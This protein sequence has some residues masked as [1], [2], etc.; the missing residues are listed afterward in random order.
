[1]TVLWQAAELLRHQHLQPYVLNVHLKLNSPRRTS[2]PSQWSETEKGNTRTIRFSEP[3]H[4][5]PPA[6]IERRSSCGNDRTLNPSVSGAEQSY[7]S[8]TRI[9]GTNPSNLHPK[10]KE[11][12]SG[13]THEGTVITKTI[14]SKISRNPQDTETKASSASKRK[15]QL[16]KNNELVRSYQTYLHACISH[17]FCY[18]N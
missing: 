1:M 7:D 8:F 17:F 10:T 14:T 11:L 13:S 9:T 15:P 18:V 3:S 2:F 16:S 6:Y 5:T 12:Y 4:V